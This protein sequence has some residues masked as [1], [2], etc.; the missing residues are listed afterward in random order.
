MSTNLTE[1]HE[2][3]RAVLDD[4][5]LDSTSQQYEASTLTKALRSVI[6]MGQLP[7]YSL[8]TDQLEVTPTVSTPT[9]FALLVYKTA[10][11]LV[12]PRPASYAFRTRALSEVFG[13]YRSFLAHI[14]E[15]IY[16]LENGEAMFDSWQTFAG[17][18]QG[19]FGVPF[20]H[21]LTHVNVTGPEQTIEL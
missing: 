18:W 9:A 20:A 3:L 15:M 21:L 19:I 1:F 17:W 7:G 2:P 8:T 13:D 12:A 5:P 10:R 4:N 14:E 16:L 11:M 6:R